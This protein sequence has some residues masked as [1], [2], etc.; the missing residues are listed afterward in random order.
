MTEFPSN[1]Q[2]P[3]RSPNKAEPKNVERIVQGEVTRRKKPLSKRLAD[4]FVGGNPRSVGSFVTADVIL[5]AVKDAIA[6]AVSQGV[7]RLIFGEGRSTSRRT[8]R[9]PSQ[10]HINYNRYS[11]SSTVGGNPALR[12]REE[13]RELSR[14]ARASHNFDEVI[15]ATRVEADEVIERLYDIVSQYE[16]ATVADL[17]DLI[18]VE[19]QWTDDKW[20]WRDLRGADIARVRN[21]YLLNLPRPEP[22]D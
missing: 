8:G 15:L 20:G 12:G 17:Y 1:S 9:M 11:N 19:G 16:S 6:D 14:R 21:G 13:P 18:G 5:P 10:S 22:L 4:V 2:R 3:P 7:E